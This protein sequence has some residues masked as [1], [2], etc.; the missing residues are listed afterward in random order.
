MTFCHQ[1]QRS[2]SH[3]DA[4]F[5]FFCLLRQT[6]SHSG[7]TLRALFTCSGSVVFPEKKSQLRLWEA[8]GSPHL[9]LHFGKQWLIQITPWSLVGWMHDKII[10]LCGTILCGE[11]FE[12]CQCGDEGERQEFLLGG[13]L[14]TRRKKPLGFGFWA[15]IKA[16][17]K[18]EKALHNP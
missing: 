3:F 12:I 9:F 7:R 11:T 1:N 17:K 4:R 18:E 14:R 10:L 2:S 15:A 5:R 16:L 6:L 13:Q 8:C